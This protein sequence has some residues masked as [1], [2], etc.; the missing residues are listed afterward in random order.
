MT[1]SSTNPGEHEQLAVSNG[2]TIAV[3]LAPKEQ[4]P[5][6]PSATLLNHR[7]CVT[8]KNAVAIPQE[9]DA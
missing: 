7:Q 8:M 4:L 3:A 1:I 2:K 9:L 5:S 6:C